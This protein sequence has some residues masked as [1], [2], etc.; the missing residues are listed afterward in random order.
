MKRLSLIAGLFAA[1]FMV[2]CEKSFLDLVPEDQQSAGSFFETEEQFMQALASAYVPLRD[3]LDNDFYTGEMRSDNTHYEYNPIN[4]GTAYV[5]RESIADF[6]NDAY[7]N[8]SN[9]VY[10]HLYKCISRANIVIDR[11]GS[12]DFSAEAKQAIEGEAK[13]LRAFS[14]FKLLRYFGSVP[15][16]LN[17]V[18]SPDDA[19]IGRSSV[20]QVYSQIIA[21]ATEAIELLNA[22]ETFPQSGHATKGAATMLLAE[23]RVERSEY[24]QA[25]SLLKS[26][27]TMGYQLLPSYADVFST[28]FKN[29]TESI[30]EVQYQMGA[31]AGQQSDL[32]YRFLPRCG[33]TSL[34][35]GVSSDNTGIGGWNTPTQDLIN[36][37]EP[38]DLR[39]DISIGVAEGN[40]D[41]SQIFTVEAVKSIENYTPE[42]GMVGVPYIKKYVNPHSLP[43]NADDNWPIYRYADALLLLA[44]ALNEQGKSGEAVTYVNQVRER[45]FSGGNPVAASG[46]QQVR[47]IILHE[48]RVELAFENHRWH[49]LVRSGTAV[50]VMS[51]YAVELKNQH[52]Y[53]NANTYQID[54]SKLLFPLPQSE[55]DLNPDLK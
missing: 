51:A 19:F 28:S 7:N 31:Q 54:E 16:Y 55:I 21:D 37:Y 6:N 25:E 50:Q 26:L 46:Q 44:E 41:G 22:P 3:F 23:V 39:K 17:E 29:S 9:A 15:L 32:I 40:Y 5:Y 10:F 49:D 35:T 8:Y 47:D 20:E 18:Q 43:L 30:F 11:I 48:R 4:R 27:N 1:F 53:L 45:A 14:Y 52:D 34:I 36:S 2:S 42:P 38:G 33:N 24:A 12:A 13:F